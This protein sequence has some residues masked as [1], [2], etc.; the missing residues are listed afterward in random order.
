MR[1]TGT[2]QGRLQQQCR[3]AL[4]LALLL[5]LLFVGGTVVLPA[6]HQAYCADQDAPHNADRCPICQVAHMPVA[7]D[8][9]PSPPQAPTI[10]I[11]EPVLALVVFCPPKPLYLLPFACGP[12]A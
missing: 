6:I 11:S 4:T 2:K 8:L 1:A 12:P 9:S 7:L 5:F 3:P 10:T